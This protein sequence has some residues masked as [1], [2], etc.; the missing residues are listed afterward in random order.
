MGEKTRADDL[1]QQIAE[2]DQLRKWSREAESAR[3]SI[4]VFLPLRVRWRDRALGFINTFGRGEF[5]AMPPEVTSAVY[6]ALAVVRDDYERKAAAI[7]RQLNKT[8][9]TSPDSG[10]DQ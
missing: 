1:R 6:E 5:H 9:P 10:S 3:S 2:V 4:R 7:E 8:V